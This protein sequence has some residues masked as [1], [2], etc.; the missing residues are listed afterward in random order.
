MTK[1]KREWIVYP[2]IELTINDLKKHFNMSENE[3]IDPTNEVEVEEKIM[4]GVEDELLLVEDD[5]NKKNYVKISPTF[6][7]QF[8]KSEEPA[9]EGEDKVDIYKIFNPKNGVVE[10]RELTVDEKQ[11]IIVKEL[12]DSKLKFKNTVHE[13]NKTITKFNTEYR[14]KRQR[15]NKMAKV[16]RKANR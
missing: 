9:V 3:I 6:Y 12:L 1:R 4:E 2:E 8:F 5:L 13:G 11:Q 7:I 16:S 15:R 14:K 10:T